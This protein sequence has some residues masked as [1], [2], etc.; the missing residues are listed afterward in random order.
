MQRS[1]GYRL[2]LHK[3][4]RDMGGFLWGSGDFAFLEESLT[5]W[6]YP[7]DLE[8]T[9][10][11]ENLY[12]VPK[13]SEGLPLRAY[14]S[15]GLRYNPTRLA[16][17]ALAHYNHYLLTTE[18]DSWLQFFKVVDWFMRAPEG[19]WVY[20]F[21]WLNL[22][23]PWLSAMAQGEGI[24]VLV[25]AWALSRD[26]HYLEQARRALVP[27]VLPLEAGGLRSALEDG[28]PF[29]E[30]YPT[31]PPA[32]VLNGFLYALIGLVDLQR[33][34]KDLV[35][36]AEI[37]A[38]L[39]TLEQHLPRWDTGFWSVY[40]LEYQRTGI[41][42]LVTPSYHNLHVAQL[43]FLGKT[44]RRPTLLKVARRWA[45]YAKQPICRWRAFW[46]KMRYRVKHPGQK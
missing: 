14:L 34:S 29:L 45:G 3:V 15:A 38:L 36:G 7:L 30:E 22:K 17:Y 39:D 27:L 31:R 13:D 33:V 26:E 20:D 5:S 9:L 42:N 25:R 19:K 46:G 40:D 28:S 10:Q 41:P 24:S 4:L 23:P 35:K 2:W 6:A 43:T 32:H 18:E 1:L 11:H 44:M 16:A 12:Y 8:F 21:P 37:E